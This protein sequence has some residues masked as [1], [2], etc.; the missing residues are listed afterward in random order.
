MTT[1]MP[2]ILL[3]EDNPADAN[4]VAEALAEEHIECEVSVLRD[5]AQAITFIDRLDADQNQPRPD[6]VLLDLNLPK[7]AGHEVLKRVRTSPRCK[8][9][10]VLIVSSS[11]A[12]ADRETALKLGANGYF[13]KPA[14]LEEFM[15]LGPRIR[16]LLELAC[17][18]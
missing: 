9:A 2:H 4:L 11:D 1:T 6:I 16:A 10:M 17:Q 3:V 12:P 18:S 7:I 5:G 8:N 13:Q 15:E 14:N